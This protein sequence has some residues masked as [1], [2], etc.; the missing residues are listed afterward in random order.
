MLGVFHL[1]TARNMRS[2]RRS[3]YVE[4]RPENAACFA[5][6]SCRVLSVVFES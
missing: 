6:P 1:F 5:L 3:F 4:M 2:I